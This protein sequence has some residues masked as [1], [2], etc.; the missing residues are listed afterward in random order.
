[1]FSSDSGMLFDTPLIEVHPEGYEDLNPQQKQSLRDLETRYE[2][3]G[4]NENNSNIVFERI[5]ATDNDANDFFA[6]AIALDSGGNAY[7]TGKF[8]GA[9]TF[10]PHTLGTLHN[11]D[12]DI[13]VAKMN[14]DGNWIWAVSAGKQGVT[15][16]IQNVDRGKDIVVDYSG[17]I[18]ITG[19]F[20][21]SAT[22][23]NISIS[24]G[25]LLDI[26]VAKLN[27]DGEWHN[28]GGDQ[29]KGWLTP[30]QVAEFIAFVAN[31]ELDTTNPFVWADEEEEEEENGS[32]SI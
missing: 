26:F 18:I 2:S 4:N 17:D 13:Y 30:D 19:E 11:N 8:A 31:G 22:F 25:W 3:N 6:H 15:T 16:N 12:E 20:A 32:S 10:G 5:T 21:G 27:S 7:I 28:C 23:G 9:I 24:S 14:S 29:V 1:M